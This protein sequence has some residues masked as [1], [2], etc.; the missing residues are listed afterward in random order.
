MRLA[1]HSVILGGDLSFEQQLEV[2][3]DAGYEGLDFS[4][5]ALAQLSDPL[6]PFT[7]YGVAPSAWGMP[8]RWQDTEA[9]FADDLAS[10]R[11]L[12]R[13]AQAID[14]PRC[15]TWMP[16]AVSGD[17]ADY[18]A[19]MVTRFRRIAEVLEPFAIRFGLEWIGPWHARQSGNICV[20]TLPDTLKLLEDIAMPNVGLMLDSW[21]WYMAGGTLCELEA[22]RP[23]QI[24]HVHFVDAPDKP[25][26]EQQDMHRAVP[27]EGIIDLVGFVRALD[28]IGG[29]VEIFGDSLRQLEPLESAAKVKA[30]CDRV[31][32]QASAAPAPDCP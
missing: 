30:A 1:L 25:Y 4:L 3:R 18:R 24:V 14:S 32:C 31:L 29:S 2:A 19:F 26:E 9:I 28:T 7:R 15:M 5:S 27:G 12:C 11:A 13:V 16:P 8:V 21:H 17:P 23:E 10:L 20:Y 22:L 6:E